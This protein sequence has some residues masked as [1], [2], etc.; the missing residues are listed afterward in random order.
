MVILAHFRWMFF[1]IFRKVL[2]ICAFSKK[3]KNQCKI[4]YPIDPTCIFDPPPHFWGHGE[5]MDKF[6]IKHYIPNNLA[7]FTQY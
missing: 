6:P 2:G 7:P 4:L 1:A 5:D 3:H